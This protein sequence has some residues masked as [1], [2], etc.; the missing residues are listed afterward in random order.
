MKK[1]K[2]FALMS[3]IILLFSICASCGKESDKNQAQTEESPY[4]IEYTSETIVSGGRSDYT[5]VIPEASSDIIEF[6]ADELVTAYEESTGVRLPIVKDAAAGSYETGKYFSVGETDLLHDAQITVDKDTLGI[7]GVI[8]QS[9]GNTVFLVGGSDSGT[10]YAVYEFLE[11]TMGYR[12]YSGDEVYIPKHDTLYFPIISG[13]VTPDFDA[14]MGPNQPVWN[15]G[16]YSRRMRFLSTSEYFISINGSWNH[17]SFFLMPPDEYLEDHKDWYAEDHQKQLCYTNTEWWDTAVENLKEVIDA[18]QERNTLLFGFEDTRDWCECED[19]L[20]SREKYGTDSAAYVQFM[21]YAVRKL[22]TWLETERSGRKI[23]FVIFAYLLTLNPPVKET[24]DGEFEPVDDSV[25]LEDNI[26]VMYAPIDAN[27]ARTFDSSENATVDRNFRGWSAC[28]DTL[29]VWSYA[30]NFHNYLVNFNNFNTMQANYKYA[31]DLHTVCYLDQSSYN[32]P[33]PTFEALRNYLTSSLLWDVEAD[34]EELI[35]DF[36]VHYYRDA[37]DA[38]K[39]YFNNMRSWFAY[40]D[41]VDGETYGNI[42]EDI[43]NTALWPKAVLDG[44]MNCFDDAYAAIEKYAETDPSLYSK[45]EYR[46]TR[47]SLSIR[48]LLIQ[49]YASSYSDEDLLAMKKSFKTDATAHGI[50]KTQEFN[51][52]I[53]NLYSSWGV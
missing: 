53:T 39:R 43:T 20:A 17:N 19:C 35:D 3:S 32:T 48:Y 52:D 22:N 1:I 45:L 13:M 14:R 34:F 49:L 8:L 10:L 6:A 16:T 11:C 46:I 37:G 21:N 28:A 29:F 2:I 30:T 7:S 51:S 41:E 33:V 44:F 12:N 36:F 38:M 31:Y 27:F 47:E 18:D 26:A 25:V 9:K 24:A 40:K 42:Y 4:S 23:Q 15:P 50:T 5:I